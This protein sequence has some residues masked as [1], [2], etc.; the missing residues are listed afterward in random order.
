MKVD[1]VDYDGYRGA[2]GGVVPEDR[3]DGHKKEDEI[4]N[5][6]PEPNED[7]RSSTRSR[8]KLVRQHTLTNAPTFWDWFKS[9]FTMTDADIEERCGNDALQYLR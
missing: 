8:R 4:S 6:V 3:K 1:E 2:V 9:I 5:A 7:V